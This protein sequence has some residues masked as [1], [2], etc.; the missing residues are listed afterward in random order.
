MKLF[1]ISSSS[2]SNWLSCK[3]I[4]K[5]LKSS[6]EL[7]RSNHEIVYFPFT[8]QLTDEKAE[9]YEQDLR[10]LAARIKNE[11]PD[12]LIFVDH[13]PL[14]PVFLLQLKNYLRISEFPEI[15]IH[16]YGDF[17]YFS[18]E[19]VKFLSGA[20]RLKIHFVVASD[21]QMRLVKHF[22]PGNVTI[23]K[24]IFPI[25]KDDYFF[26]E[27]L[28]SA[29]RKKMGIADD[30]SVIIYTGRISLQKNVEYLIKEFISLCRRHPENKNKILIVGGF[31][32]SGAEI[33]GVKT[34]EGY[35]YLKFQTILERLPE[36]IRN[37][38]ILFGQQN[39]TEVRSLLCA[40][41]MYCSLSLFHDDD[42][43]MAPA[44]ALATGLPA[45][46]TSWG[47]YSSFASETDEWACRLLGVGITHLGHTIDMKLFREAFSH[48]FSGQGRKERSEAFLKKFGIS[49]AAEQ[50]ESFLNR[51]VSFLG[52]MNFRLYHYS[53]L[54][55]IKNQKGV[56][57]Y[58]L[59]S[60]QG[61]YHSVYQNYIQVQASSSDE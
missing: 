34:Y 49:S 27:E 33:F 11:I 61:I 1:I 30:E 41:D 46:L 13:F 48:A 52:E 60:D 57:E 39:K 50:I 25:D 14:P 37:K 38:I 24:C 44:E 28:R 16:V 20:D 21:A 43:G 56:A 26:D 40:S 23:D 19:W 53:N 31:D 6:Y 55:K 32:D 54:S 22:L 36:Q 15:L 58:F 59:P 5:N 42:F 12:R 35:L 10:N 2:D 3:T 45:Y 7:L 4:S 51:K 8:S 9:S 18:Q 47:G 29:T 17:T